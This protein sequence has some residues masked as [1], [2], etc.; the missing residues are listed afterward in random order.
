MT[1]SACKLVRYDSNVQLVWKGE[2]RADAHL[3]AVEHHRHQ[4]S[5]VSDDLWFV[6]KHMKA[7]GKPG[8][9]LAVGDVLKLGRVSLRVKALS[10]ESHSAEQTQDSSEEESDLP[11]ETGTCRICLSD[12]VAADN[13]L[14][15]P[16]ECAG[17]VRLI[18]FQCLQKWIASRKVERESENARTASWKSLDCEL[19]KAPYPHAL[20]V[21]GKPLYELEAPQSPFLILESVDRSAGLHLVAVTGN[22]PLKV[23]RGHDADVRVTDISVSRVHASIHLHEGQFVLRD[24]QSKFGTLVKARSP[25]LLKPQTSA[26]FQ[27]GRTLIAVTATHTTF[28]S[29]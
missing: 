15:S 5:L 27:S 17:S 9:V 11:A 10:G 12:E 13:P 14:I 23:G 16:C 6:V 20:R 4:F 19:C 24:N 21:Q 25:V 29:K 1:S 2:P 28:S 22:R 18:H 7:A 3:L 26:V 8:A